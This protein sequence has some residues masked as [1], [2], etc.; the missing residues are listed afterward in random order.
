MNPATL[1]LIAAAMPI[2]VSLTVREVQKLLP[3]DYAVSTVR[4]A[5]IALAAGGRADVE[6]AL[7]GVVLTKRY[8]LRTTAAI[9]ANP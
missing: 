3:I 9:G 8:C 6:Q 1:A 7:A 2:G 5:L 4:L